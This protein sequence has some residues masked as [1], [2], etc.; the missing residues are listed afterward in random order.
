MD[1]AGI[2]ARE[3]WGTQW[4]KLLSVLYEGATTGL[5]GEEGRLIGGKSAE[6][7]AARVRVQLEIERIMGAVT[8]T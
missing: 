4:V 8:A 7:I 1:V 5:F 6:G 3:I 2:K